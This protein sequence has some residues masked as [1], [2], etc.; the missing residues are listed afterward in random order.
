MKILVVDDDQSN[1]NVIRDVLEDR[2][3]V[4]IAADGLAAI[5]QVL[6]ER[7]DLVLLDLVLPDMDG[8]VVLAKIR[9][10]SRA[11][12]IVL[13]ARHQQ[14]DVVISLKQGGDDFLAKPF[15]LDE[16]DARIEAVFR[17]SRRIPLPEPG[18]TISETHGFRVDG[19]W[20]PLTLL[21]HNVMAALLA[22]PFGE[23]VKHADLYQAGWGMNDSTLSHSLTNC[24]Y[25]LRDRL[26][27]VPGA[28]AIASVFG[29]GFYL[30]PASAGVALMN[31]ECLGR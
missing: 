9:Q 7:P 26:E 3:E 17:R 19:T 4:V 25:R 12:V 28:P 8:L 14:V 16:L 21:E 20:V 11:P 27:C 31:G 5:H 2:Y 30:T 10:F 1:R 6:T 18:L 22:R 13:S 29:K 15:D 23:V 24:I